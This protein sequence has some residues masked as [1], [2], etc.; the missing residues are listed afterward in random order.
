MRM[1]QGAVGVAPEDGLVSPDYTV[2]RPRKNVN[3]RYFEYF[4]RTD[5]YKNE[6]NRFSHGIVPDRNRLYWEQFKQMPSL[7][8]PFEEQNKIVKYLD[9]ETKVAWQLIQEIQ[10]MIELL[11]EY[12][13]SLVSSVVTGKLD[14]R[15]WSEK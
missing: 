8:P 15:G 12:R 13:S 7:C 3:P 9:C 6:I 4:F 1:W 14:L 10:K 2:A 11:H 5:L